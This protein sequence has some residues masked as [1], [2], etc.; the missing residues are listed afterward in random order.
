MFPTRLDGFLC[1]TTRGGEGSAFMP[2]WWNSGAFGS[3]TI[4]EDDCGTYYMHVTT[5]PTGD[6]LLVQMDGVETRSVTDLRT[7]R[8]LPFLNRGCLEIH[9]RDWADVATYGDRVL[10]VKAW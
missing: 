10:K 8:A 2:G 4:P 6:R 3:V 5:P 9:D 7:G 1:K